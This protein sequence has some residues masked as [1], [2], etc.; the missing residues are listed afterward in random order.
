MPVS[1][2]RVGRPSRQSVET[3]TDGSQNRNSAHRPVRTEE[4]SIPSGGGLG[5]RSGSGRTEA[6]GVEGSIEAE[7]GGTARPSHRWA[8]PVIIRQPCDFLA[9]PGRCCGGGKGSGGVQGAR[10]CCAGGDVSRFHRQPATRQD[11][12]PF[13]SPMHQPLSPFRASG[14]ANPNLSPRSFFLRSVGP[15]PPGEF[16]RRFLLRRSSS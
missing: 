9:L 8:P 4:L 12:H 3:Q 7:E 16:S 11:P 10:I 5:T 14:V 13:A 15:L 6:Q 2:H 1:S